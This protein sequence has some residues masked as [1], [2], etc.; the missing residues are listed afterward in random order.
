MNYKIIKKE[1]KRFS[2]K[3]KAHTLQYFFKTGK[4]QYGEGDV[5]IGVTSPEM[6]QIAKKY[7]ETISLAEVKQLLY[8]KIHEERLTALFLLV[9]KYQ[10]IKSP[11]EKKEVCEFYLKNLK[12]VNNWDLVDI[13][14]YKIVGDYLYNHVKNKKILYKLAESKNMW[15]QRVS[16]VSTMYF[17]RKNDLKDT[18]KLSEMLLNHKHD[19]MHKAVGWLLR[20][21]GKKDEKLLKKFLKKHYDD[22]PRTTLRY[23]IERMEEKE[24]K[25]YLKK[26]F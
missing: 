16:I 14:C 17:V 3:D 26:D 13:S 15:E 19:L 24:R 25:K 5:F 6:Q 4:G 8:S 21:V 12:Q 9:Y 1:L 7:Y 18:I 2:N 23:S 22:I 20:E 10:K 11:K